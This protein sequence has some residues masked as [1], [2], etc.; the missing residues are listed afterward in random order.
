MVRT[1]LSDK[2]MGALE[3]ARSEVREECGY[4]APLSS[5]RHVQ[6]IPGDISIFGERMTIFYAEVT[7]SMRAG[8]GGGL[9]EEGE[10][11][12]IVELSVAEMKKLLAEPEVNVS[13]VTL[14]GLMWF[15]KHKS[16]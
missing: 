6:S 16:L 3:I 4:D 12:E 7:D 8:T 9:A 10:L 14:Y 11:I 13:A 1:N 5:F 15:L 2:E